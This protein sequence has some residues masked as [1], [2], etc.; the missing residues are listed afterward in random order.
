MSPNIRI[1]EVREP[2]KLGNLT[3]QPFYLNHPALCLAY[4][5]S[6][7]QRRVVYATDNEPYYDVLHEQNRR[8]SQTSDFPTYLDEKFVEFL[9]RADLYIGEAQ[10]TKEEYQ[11]KKGW[12]HSPLE[13]TVRFAVQA[14]VKKL[15]L[16]HY[17]PLH[18]DKFI[19]RMIEDAKQFVRMYAGGTECIG[20]REGLEIVVS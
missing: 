12:G 11:E 1:H 16:F 17:D 2:Q 19:G 6:D 8:G 14:N 5:V 15:A 9:S 18:D 3:V 20:A 4:A 13:A 7:G 10:Y